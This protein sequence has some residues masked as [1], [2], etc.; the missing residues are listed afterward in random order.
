MRRLFSKSCGWTLATIEYI[1]CAIDRHGDELVDFAKA[2]RI[3]MNRS[4]AAGVLMACSVVAQMPALAAVTFTK[5][6]LPIL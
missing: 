6:V 3:L 1:R 4:I 5:G 2:G